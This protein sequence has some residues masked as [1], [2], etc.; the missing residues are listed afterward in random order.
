VGISGTYELSSSGVASGNR[1][2]ILEVIF[3]YRR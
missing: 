3:R 2:F 1:S